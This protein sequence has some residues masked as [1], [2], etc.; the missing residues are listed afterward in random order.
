MF[1]KL[2]WKDLAN[3]MFTMS[4]KPKLASPN[5]FC[6]LNDPEYMSEETQ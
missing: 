1:E 4:M 5:V 3:K 2:I 6:I